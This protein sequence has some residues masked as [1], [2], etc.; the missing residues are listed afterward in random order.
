MGDLT[1]NFSRS[2][3]ACGILLSFEESLNVSVIK[4]SMPP[5]FSGV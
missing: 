1:D 5:V 4:E 3:F 2:E